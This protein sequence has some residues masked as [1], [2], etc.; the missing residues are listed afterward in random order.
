MIELTK[1]RRENKVYVNYK[2]I[3]LD[4]EVIT[5]LELLELAG[6][7]FL[8]YDCYLAQNEKEKGTKK[9]TKKKNKPLNE[10]NKIH[11]K[12]GIQFN[13]TLKHQ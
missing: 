11:T 5:P 6:F 9:K 13:S 12:T 8:V 2:A 10:N 7:S 4:K 3:I 1:V